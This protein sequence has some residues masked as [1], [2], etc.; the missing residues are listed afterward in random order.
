MSLLIKTF[1]VA[2]IVSV[3][4]IGSLTLY[5]DLDSTYHPNTTV[6]FQQFYETLNTT[7]I[8]GTDE[9]QSAA[10]EMGGNLSTVPTTTVDTPDESLKAGSFT[11][12]LVVFKLPSLL[13]NLMF[14]IAGYL[15]IPGWLVGMVVS[16]AIVIITVIGIALVFNR[17]P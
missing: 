10:R 13:S 6:E 7:T 3:F 11:S 16:I 5:N 14:G 2:L 4:L 1:T 8:T 15:G 9:V 12:F 17:R